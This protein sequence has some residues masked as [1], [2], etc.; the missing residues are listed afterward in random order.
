MLIAW[1]FIALFT[2]NALSSVITV[3]KPR[4]PITNNE[5]CAIVI[6]NAL[7]IYGIVYLTWGG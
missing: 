5:A 3:G 7:M 1:G 6:G 2:L 4:E